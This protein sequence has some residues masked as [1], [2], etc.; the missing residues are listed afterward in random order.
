MSQ[1]DSGLPDGFGRQRCINLSLLD[2]GVAAVAELASVPARPFL[3]SG[4]ATITSPL[5]AWITTARASPDPCSSSPTTLS[6][7]SRSCRTSFRRIRAL[8]RRPVQPGH[9]SGTNSFHGR[10]YEYFQNR[11]LN[12]Q[13]SVNRPVSQP[14]SAPFNTRYDNNRFGGQIGGPIIKNKLFYFVN[15]EYNPIGEAAV[16][17][18]AAIAPT[19]AGWATILGI[20]GGGRQ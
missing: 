18:T 17:T 20:P 7:S 2:A 10:I 5:R 15:F 12:A 4:R 14:G 16:P 6:I 1:A 19:A 8:L 13:D 9:R 3:A 11:N